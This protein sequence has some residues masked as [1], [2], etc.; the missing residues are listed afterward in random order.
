MKYPKTGKFIDPYSRLLVARG[1]WEGQWGETDKRLQNILL[2]VLKM[3]WTQIMMVVTQYG[4][5][6]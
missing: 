4:E 1:W 2:W 6:Y 3:F 5:R